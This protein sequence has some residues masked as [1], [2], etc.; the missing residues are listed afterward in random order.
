V[1]VRDWETLATQSRQMAGAW[2][3]PKPSHPRCR[4]GPHAPLIRAGEN[5]AGRRDLPHIASGR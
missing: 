1:T 3:A 2:D 5:R 4:L